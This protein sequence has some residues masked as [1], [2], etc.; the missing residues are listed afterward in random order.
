MDAFWEDGIA[1]SSHNNIGPNFGW[2]CVIHVTVKWLPG[3]FTL[4]IS[5]SH[6][7]LELC[8]VRAGYILSV[9]YKLTIHST[10][11]QS[12]MT[13]HSGYILSVQYKLTIHFTY[14]QSIKTDHSGYILSVQYK[15]TIHSTYQQSIKT[16]H[17]LP[18][19]HKIIISGEQKDRQNC[20]N[21]FT[22]EAAACFGLCTRQ[23]Q[24]YWRI[25]A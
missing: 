22:I 15:L 21:I 11:Q 4:T 5:K 13:D 2:K 9:Q 16:D 1:A 14:Q 12:I 19:T 20:N 24:M 6:K 23:Y 18:L 17:S 8:A 3:L 25:I 7:G 10:Y